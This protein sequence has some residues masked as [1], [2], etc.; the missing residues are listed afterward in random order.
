MSNAKIPIKEIDD[1]LEIPPVQN[2][3]MQALNISSST[4]LKSNKSLFEKIDISNNK[5]EALG[6][7]NPERFKRT[8]I[9]TERN[10]SLSKNLKF[11]Y[12][13]QCQV[14][15]ERVQSGIYN[16]SC[17]SHHI[18]PVGGK[19]QGP[20]VA[21]NIIILCPNHHL[22]FDIGA[23]TIYLQT[24]RVI[25]VNNQNAIHHSNLILKHKIEEKFV[26]YHNKNIFKGSIT[27]EQLIEV[28]VNQKPNFDSLVILIDPEGEENKFIFKISIIL[29]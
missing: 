19:H 9:T 25:H 8:V 18:Q 28:E 23:I 26:N 12:N 15:G 1:A 24:K 3:Q 10:Q 2:K 29:I 6:A 20:D 11:L 21:S 14:C 17:E 27:L 13:H 7:S 16:Y 22:M 5:F 4:N